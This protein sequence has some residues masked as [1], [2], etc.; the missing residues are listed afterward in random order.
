VAIAETA[1]L[2]VDLSLKGNFARQLGQSGRALGTFD[3]KLA[4]TEGRAYRAGQQIGTGIKRGLAIGV[5]GI[6]LLGYEISQGLDSL[7]KLEAQTEATNAVIKST[8]GVAGITAT[9]VRAMAEEF[10]SLN[11]LFGDEVIQSAENM[12]L[13]FTNIGKKAFKPTLQA[14]L[15]LNAGLGRG[16]EGLA[17]TAKTL[18]VALNDPTKGLGR[19]S[20]AGITFLA[21]QTK[22]IKKLQ[23]EGK[24]YQAQAIILKEVQKRFGGRFAAFGGETAR[25]VA[26]FHDAIEDLQ[27]TLAAG[28]LPVVSNIADALSDLFKDPTIQKG[29]E[30]FGKDLAAFFTPGRIKEF[31]GGIKD[32][33][34]AIVDAFRLA[35]GAVKPL[36]TAFNSLPPDLKKLLLGAIVLEKATG[37]LL[38]NVI[39]GIGSALKTIFAANV[40][41]VGKTVTGP[42]GLPAPG[43][44]GGAAGA[45]G[46]GGGV[47]GALKGLAGLLV[48]GL[49]AELASQF[50]PEISGLGARLGRGWRDWLE[51]QTGIK[52]PTI[53]PGQLQWPFGPKNTPTILPEIFGNNGLLG[54]KPAQ[55]NGGNHPGV[56]PGSVG[57]IERAGQKTTDAVNRMKDS[58]KDEIFGMHQ[59]I[60]TVAQRAGEL[61]IGFDQIEDRR[62]QDSLSTISSI[63]NTKTSVDATKNAVGDAKSAITSTTSVQ[64]AITRTRIGTASATNATIVA[65]ATRQG[66]AA[67]VAA[68]HSIPPPSI[69]VTTVNRS[70]TV[71]QRYGNTTSRV[72]NVASQG[73][74]G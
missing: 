49:V 64:S 54:G 30:Q 59:G 70:Q 55:P 40:T 14:A 20:K 3:A 72:G 36:I 48:V 27:R 46:K 68:I 61:K 22:R 53:D 69:N 19:L 23:K 50:G 25:K 1:K 74:H 65:G 37:G 16:P 31:I 11:A 38:S 73:G 15:D 29:V 18:G 2:V 34:G 60:D 32:F 47:G 26:K 41:V 42:G 7:V 21:E 24:L 56:I 10:E 63:D 4:Q 58:M 44:A 6:G 9:Q 52:I 51:S 62:A 35:A 13:S 17:N 8:G 66:S 39:G 33:A 12:L 5:A 45:G 43:G 57:A 71:I 28:L 67:I